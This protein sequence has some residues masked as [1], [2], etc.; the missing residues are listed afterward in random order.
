VRRVPVQSRAIAS[1]GY[2]PATNVLELEFSD[3]DVYR[4]YAVPRRVHQ[5]LLAAES[6]GRYFQSQI[7]EQ[8][9]YERI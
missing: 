5:E 7:R 4:Y 8:Y 9:G 2:D 3:G 1:V 6:M